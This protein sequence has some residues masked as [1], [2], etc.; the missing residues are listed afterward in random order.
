MMTRTIDATETAGFRRNLTVLI[1][2]Q[3]LG[4]A[5][6]PIVIS[7][8][9]LVG[10]DLATDPALATVPVSIYNLGLALGTVPAAW[11][12]R[13]YGRRSGYL[14][15]AMI[16]VLSGL[17]AAGAISFG[18]FIF[19]CLGTFLAGLY[20]SYVQSYRFA[21]ADGREGADRGRAIS[22]VMVG[23]L[24]AAI[25]GPQLVIATRDAV[26]GVPFAGSFL[27]QA[28]LALIAFFV[29]TRLRGR[30]PAVTAQ[31]SSD[32]GGRT[33]PQLLASPK[34]MLGVAAGVV[35]Y[36]LMS[37]VMTA[38]PLA[39]VGCGHS[40][41]HAAWGIQ[42]HVLAM[43]APSLVTGKLIARFGKEKV[44]AAGLIIIGISGAV[45]LT[46]LDLRHFFISLILLGIGWNFGFI[47]ATA[48]VAA[49][50]TEAE[51]G[52]AQGLNDFAVFGTVA[53]LSFFSGALMQAS[54]WHLINLLMFPFI[55]IVLAPLVWQAA[56]RV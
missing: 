16:G 47:G 54:G 33:V 37:F 38:A 52:R 23:G 34:Y 46:G 39:M 9:G 45:A 26:P 31:T 14:L 30:Q 12:M 20:A 40:I 44:T 50:H 15:G 53:A 55:A 10:Q 8:G 3:S 42:W 1:L 49:A 48:M 32:D 18:A 25:I 5:S 28:A 43:F 4:A 35:S 19:F 22:W 56:R 11:I 36:G 24:V 17:I 7:L 51:R 21:A 41:D 2:A 29:L 6:G 27:S 13:Q